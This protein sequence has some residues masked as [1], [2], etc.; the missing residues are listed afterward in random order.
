MYHTTT[1]VLKP[2]RSVPPVAQPRAVAY[3]H[4]AARSSGMAVFLGLAGYIGAMAVGMAV[5]ATAAMVLH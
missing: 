1:T 3:E 4:P 5:L 2:R